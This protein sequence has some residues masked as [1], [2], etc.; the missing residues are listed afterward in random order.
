MV[1]MTEEGGSR[2]QHLLS[3]LFHVSRWERKRAEAQQISPE[4][5]HSWI[6]LLHSRG[7]FLIMFPTKQ[8]NNTF[9]LKIPTKTP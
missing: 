4:S 2:K 5:L 8:K 3:A 7:L 9:I 6:H 1:M